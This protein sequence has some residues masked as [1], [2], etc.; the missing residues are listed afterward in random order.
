MGILSGLTKST[1]HPSGCFYKL[2]VPLVGA[3]RIRALLFGVYT[4]VPDF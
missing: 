1:D 2:G 4:G 3:L